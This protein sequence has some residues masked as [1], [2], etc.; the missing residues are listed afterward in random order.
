[1]IST[2]NPEIEQEIQEDEQLL[3]TGSPKR[4]IMFRW[5][6]VFMIPYSVL[7]LWGG[8]QAVS[9]ML[10]MEIR[11]LDLY[12]VLSLLPNMTPM[13][14]GLYLLVGRYLVDALQRRNITYVVTNQRT[15]ILSRFLFFRKVE[16]IF[17]S[18]YLKVSFKER[19]SGIG[20]IT[21]SQRRAK[22]GE[23][24]KLIV[25][26]VPQERT[27]PTLEAVEQAHEVYDIIIRATKEAMAREPSRMM[28]EQF[29]L[30]Q[31]KARLTRLADKPFRDITLWFYIVIAFATLTST[32]ELP[33]S[34]GLMINLNLAAT[35]FVILIGYLYGKKSGL[36]GGLI[37]FLPGLIF[38]LIG[39][40]ALHAGF[41]GSA[42]AGRLDM[43]D[44]NLRT[45]GVTYLFLAPIGY[46]TAA[47]KEW[48]YASEKKYAFISLKKHVK[49][50][51]AGTLIPALL[52]TFSFKLTDRLS[53][54]LDEFYY[55]VPM[56]VSYYYGLDKAYRFLAFMSPFFLFTLYLGFF[57]FGYNVSA[58]YM[59]IFLFFLILGGTL[60]VEKNKDEDPS[61]PLLFATMLVVG[62][63][64][65][66]TYFY[67]EVRF[68]TADF[69]LPFFLLVGLLFGPHRGFWFG[70]VWGLTNIIYYRLSIELAFGGPSLHLLAAPLIGYL[71]GTDLF[72]GRKFLYRGAYVVV[73]FNLLFLIAMLINGSNRL[74]MVKT[75]YVRI[76]ALVQ[77]LVMVSA[78]GAIL[79]L[80][81][82]AKKNN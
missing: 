13:F 7:V 81:E 41:E 66:L 16:T 54:N 21:F 6:D 52:L 27:I 55:L 68:A 65:N 69:A 53:I 61:F 63:L 72:N 74:F 78:I 25:F 15:I 3:W 71:G 46:L 51:H 4:G 50:Y 60:K 18:D 33:V 70:I 22:R 26:G 23:T 20:T 80:R 58:G 42:L 12:D 9:P 30:E 34:N 77:G 1:M 48:L 32:I 24:A 59:A 29:A 57:S 45:L 5:V 82:K 76:T 67:N 75:Y 2:N 49:A 47:C 39:V 8:I 36:V 40:T 56:I 17:L 19:R 37:V 73:A 79:F 31:E 62:M 10:S 38:H 14:Y 43:G 11:R 44:L 35:V 28:I 64:F